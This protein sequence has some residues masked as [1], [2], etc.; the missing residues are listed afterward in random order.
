[1]P[2][3]I[4]IIALLALLTGL[5]AG[6]GV[7]DRRVDGLEERVEALEESVEAFEE[8]IMADRGFVPLDSLAASAPE[9]RSISFSPR[10]TATPAGGE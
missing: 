10:A 3:A 5:V 7:V 6:D 9:P 2:T 4:I 8:Q 1:M